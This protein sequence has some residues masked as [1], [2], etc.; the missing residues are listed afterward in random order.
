[1][2]QRFPW[3]LVAAA[4][5][6][7]LAAAL[8]VAWL[9]LSRPDGAL[10]ESR[11]Q[12]EANETL[13]FGW[14]PRFPFIGAPSEP[15]PSPGRRSPSAAGAAQII[16]IC[17]LGQATYD[18]T[19]GFAPHFQ[20]M[21]AAG[22][23][24][25]LAMVQRLRDDPDPQR[26]AAGLFHLMLI[27]A[28]QAEA[29]VERDHANCDADASCQEAREAAGARAMMRER[30]ELARM[31]ASSRDPHVYVAG[32]AACRQAKDS[33]HALHAACGQLSNLRWSELDPG[34]AA[35]WL[36]IA[37]EAAGR[38]A[39]AE[40][41]AALHQV[42]SSTTTDYRLR[43]LVPTPLLAPSDLSPVAMLMAQVQAT[44]VYA[45]VPMVGY[46]E[47]VK[48][49]EPERL[50]D[51]NRR[52]LCRQLAEHFAT[53][54]TTLIG[55]VSGRKLVRR[56]GW[57][58][59]RLQ[60]LDD[61]IDALGGVDFLGFDSFPHMLSCRSLELARTFTTETVRSGEIPA[62]RAR[63]QASGKSI[64]QAASE[65]R[66]ALK[67]AAERQQADAKKTARTP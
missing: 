44:G 49:C 1:M 19:A 65:N 67:R 52:E 38:K 34:N 46:A 56:P 62:A 50:A 12:S 37:H 63:L 45:A 40:V 18:E 36:A 43:A 22:Q 3:W 2:N 59:V 53:H 4:V 32:L 17:G 28:E 31:A 9:Q 21:E 47:A 41:V 11:P 14:P 25:W 51:A 20:R 39:E 42:L 8:L 57:D 23:K 15:P 66:A 10:D 13:S 35:P 26:R 48:T 5:A 16:D 29:R 33:E 55:L 64:A 61:D 27:R 54:D 60:A 7:L 24:E 58:Q 30:L 6:G